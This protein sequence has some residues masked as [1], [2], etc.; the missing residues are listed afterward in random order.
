MKIPSIPTIIIS[1]IA[2]LGIVA[3]AQP[4]GNIFKAG[5]NNLNS[6]LEVPVDILNVDKVKND[7]KVKINNLTAKMESMRNEYSQYGLKV[8]EL[9]ANA[10]GSTDAV[11][12]VNEG[13]LKLIWGGGVSTPEQTAQT[14]QKQSEGFNTL[15][16]TLPRLQQQ[17]QGSD[18]KLFQDISLEIRTGRNKLT[19]IGN[20]LISQKTDF[21]NYIQGKTKYNINDGGN[22]VIN[23]FQYNGCIPT[24][25]G[26]NDIEDAYKWLE[27]RFFVPVASATQKTFET[28]I[29]QPVLTPRK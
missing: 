5:Q 18:A 26:T 11:K 13:A 7:C 21:K 23:I 20:E 28:K 2:I 16:T 15:V 25:R 19:Q 3:V 27:D 6:K 9:T 4:L 24:A 22:Q 14:V 12:S 17:F 10:Q 29:D 1:L 8:Q